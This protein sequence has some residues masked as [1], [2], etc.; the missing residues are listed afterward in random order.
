MPIC[1]ENETASLTNIGTPSKH[2]H[3]PAWTEHRRSARLTPERKPRTEMRNL[4]RMMLFSM[5]HLC[6]TML[7]DGD[8]GEKEEKRVTLCV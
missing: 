5:E 2:A 3:D 4:Q 8:G 7:D 1:L 6:T